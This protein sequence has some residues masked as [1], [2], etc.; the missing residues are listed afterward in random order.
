MRTQLRSR[1]ALSPGYGRDN[2][3]A[4]QQSDA[5]IRVLLADD[6]AIVR[7]GLKLLIDSQKDMEVV[8]EV[9][10]GRDAV[11]RAHALQP[12][13]VVLDISMPELN[14]LE[15]AREIV[16]V[17]PNVAVVTLSRYSDEGYVQALIAAGARAYILKQSASTELLAAIRAVTEGRRYLDA[18]LTDRVTGAFLARHTEVASH[19]QISDREGEV[20]RLIAIGY[21]NKEIAQQLALSVKTIEVHKANAMRKLDLRGRVDIVRYAVHHGWLHDT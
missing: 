18:A 2:P 10:T 19:V 20:L 14:G 8:G 16:S 1:S 7:H 15:A 12:T 11:E 6:H 5:V 3:P 13:V 4:L 17:A 21:S 9:G